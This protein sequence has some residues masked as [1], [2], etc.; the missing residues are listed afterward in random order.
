MADKIAKYLYEQ[1]KLRK[2]A[3]K[4]K[5]EE[6]TMKELLPEQEIVTRLDFRGERILL[7]EFITK[8]T[9]FKDDRDVV[10]KADKGR[11]TMEEYE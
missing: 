5:I 2:D 8:L 9:K 10:V 4:K 11:L 7:P 6:K 1:T 3:G